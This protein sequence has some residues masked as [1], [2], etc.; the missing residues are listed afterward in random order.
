MSALLIT[1]TLITSSHTLSENEIKKL[2]LTDFA[3][4]V[5]DGT[6]G[7]AAFDFKSPHDPLCARKSW[8]FFDELYVCLGAGISC[9]RNLPVA[10]TLNQC[11]LRSDVTISIGNRTSMIENGEGKY[12]GVDWVFQDGI[13]YVFPA[14]TTV[15]IKN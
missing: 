11:L 3:G 9:K 4:A 2:G 8:F 7:A 5:T 6:Y 14:P 12:E 13:G 1:I 10:T 15:F